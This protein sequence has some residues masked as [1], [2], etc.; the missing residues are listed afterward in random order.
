MG[1]FKLMADG[2][3]APNGPWP[4]LEFDLVTVAGRANDVGLPI[5]LP[6]LDETNQLCVNADDGRDADVAAGAGVCADDCGGG[7]DVPGRGAERVRDGDAGECGQGADVAGVRAAAALRGDDS[8]GG[9]DVQSAG[10]D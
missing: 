8:A 6:K 5:Y 9:D 1:A 2:S 7:G 10:A 4:T 3:T